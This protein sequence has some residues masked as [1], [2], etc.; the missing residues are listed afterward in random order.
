MLA[1]IVATVGIILMIIGLASI[2][3]WA[4]WNW[5]MPVIFGL[6]MISFWQALGLLFLSSIMFKST[7]K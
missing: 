1:K 6:P 5:L 2:P 4:L 3:F 7:S